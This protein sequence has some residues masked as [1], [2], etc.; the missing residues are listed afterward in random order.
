MEPE[1]G[2]EEAGEA[3]VGSLA[4]SVFWASLMHGAEFGAGAA[5]TGGES[6]PKA[7]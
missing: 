3:Q 6:R 5:T 7:S 4:D 1:T 2:E